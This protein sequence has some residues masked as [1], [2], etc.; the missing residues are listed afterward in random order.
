[1]TGHNISIS[2][3]AHHALMH[4]IDH[5]GNKEITKQAK[6]GDFTNLITAMIGGTIDTNLCVKCGRK[7]EKRWS[8]EKNYNV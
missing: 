2:E 1:M 4:L 6:N 8:E 7:L 5:M 3:E